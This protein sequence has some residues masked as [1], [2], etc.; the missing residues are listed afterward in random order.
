M[1]IVVLSEKNTR[2]NMNEGN[3]FGLE[4]ERLLAIPPSLYGQFKSASVRRRR[5][6]GIQMKIARVSPNSTCPECWNPVE[7][8][9]RVGKKSESMTIGPLLYM[10][11]L[12]LLPESWNLDEIAQG[13]P[14]LHVSGMLESCRDKLPCLLE[15]GADD[16][17][18]A[19]STTTPSILAA[20][21]KL[22]L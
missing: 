13:K 8:N 22:H 11:N 15:I 16:N 9:F 14:K 6:P 1:I 2:T 4:K 20:F 5:N 21:A 7:M 10:G 3:F 12:N 19:S 17:W 18:S